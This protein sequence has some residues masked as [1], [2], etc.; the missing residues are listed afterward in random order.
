LHLQTPLLADLQRIFLRLTCA[1]TVQ[2]VRLERKT[3]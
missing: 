2:A 1:Q 3:P